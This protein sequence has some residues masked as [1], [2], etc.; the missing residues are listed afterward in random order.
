MAQGAVRRSSRETFVTFECETVSVELG[1]GNVE[2]MVGVCSRKR[3][4][5]GGRGRGD[6]ERERE[7]P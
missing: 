7:F 4:S 5:C 1:T 2:V 6:G 3:V